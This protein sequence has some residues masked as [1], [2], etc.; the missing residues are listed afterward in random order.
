MRRGQR[1]VGPEG[2][3]FQSR[4]SVGPARGRG[5]DVAFGGE[6]TRLDLCF[7]RVALAAA[8][9]VTGRWLPSA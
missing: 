5:P 1:A 8:S 6:V 2:T 7:R 4:A 3:A 9:W